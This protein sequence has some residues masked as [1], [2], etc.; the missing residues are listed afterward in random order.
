MAVLHAELLDAWADIFE[1][2][3]A[4]LQDTLEEDNH[5][6]Y[7]PILLQS[8]CSNRTALLHTVLNEEQRELLRKI[9]MM[10]NSVEN[11][12]KRNRKSHLVKHIV[13]FGDLVRISHVNEDVLGNDWVVC[14]EVRQFGW[15]HINMENH[16]FV[17][18]Q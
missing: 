12:Q 16:L 10:L 3:N 4:L 14:D 8:C 13:V 15:A 17:G 1:V 6:A 9:Y 7:L 2:H 5:D 18:G 11:F